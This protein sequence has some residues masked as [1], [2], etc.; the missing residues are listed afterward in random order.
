MIIRRWKRRLRRF[1]HALS[2][3]KT[4]FSGS[5]EPVTLSDR[6]KEHFDEALR[7]YE[8]GEEEKAR[9]KVEELG[10]LETLPDEFIG[11]LLEAASHN[12]GD[13]GM[14]H[15]GELKECA[16]RLSPSRLPPKHW[17]LLY[18]L[19]FRNG[20][21]DT[22]GILR[23]NAL[24][25]ARLEAEG[26]ATA[27]QVERSF[28]AAL[29]RGNFKRA[30]RE[31]DRLEERAKLP[32]TLRKRYLVYL[33]LNS[34]ELSEAVRLA[35]TLPGYSWDYRE[36][37]EGKSV[38]VAGPA[39]SREAVGREID[40]FDAVI[41]MNYGHAS[42]GGSPE[43]YGSRTDVSYYN[44]TFLENIR[45]R[46]QFEGLEELDFAVFKCSRS[47]LPK[48]FLKHDKIRTTTASLFYF[49]GFPNLGQLSI[50]D[51]LLYL[52]SRIKVFHMNFYHDA[53]VHHDDYF[54]A[55]DHAHENHLRSLALHDCL[56]QI[57]FTR[58]LQTA[59]LIEADAACENVLTM[60]DPTYLNGL[61]KFYVA[62]A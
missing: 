39:S 52:P 43:I 23:E 2:P 54:T 28:R 29:D 37:L 19:C 14:D 59:G 48:R 5:T 22:A 26:D 4:D 47:V 44:R 13:G 50:A 62:G 6:S 25:A 3:W 18:Q 53:T 55:H 45:E 51:L 31:F 15:H 33:H 11:L 8:E 58:H 1:L 56:S 34:G 10:K 7:Y 12:R 60:D 49:N 36:Y 27:E 17:L 61:E 40:E 38:A 16:G 35:E 57:R 24:D 46:Q 30:R 20:L 9:R 21:L 41:R 32:R 42:T